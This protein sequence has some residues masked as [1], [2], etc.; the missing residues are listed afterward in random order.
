MTCVQEKLNKMAQVGA[1]AKKILN[2]LLQHCRVG[3]SSAY[4]DTLAKNYS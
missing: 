1:K 4:L 2:M 3:V